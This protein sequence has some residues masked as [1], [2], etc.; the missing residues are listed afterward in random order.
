[1]GRNVRTNV[2]RGTAVLHRNGVTAADA[3]AVPGT[4][5]VTAQTEAGSVLTNVLRNVA[6][7]AGNRWGVTTTSTGSAT[8]TTNQAV[9]IAFAAVP[10][11]DYYDI[12]LSTDAQP[13]WITRITEAQRAAGGIASAVGGYAAGGAVNSIDVGIDGTGLGNAVAPFAAN[14]AYTPGS[15]ASPINCAGFSN[16]HVLVKATVADLRSL[17]TVQILPF[18]AND[19]SPGDWHS[20]AAQSL[21]PGVNASSTFAQEF[22]IPVNGASQMV[23]ALVSNLAGQGVSVSAWVQLA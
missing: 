17:P 8:P 6:V 11:A 14:T 23:V 9:R 21:A 4:L 3:L 15:I 12:F 13:K 22:I 18:F 19:L 20:R 2:I 10:G 5:T 7:S 1:V 16:A